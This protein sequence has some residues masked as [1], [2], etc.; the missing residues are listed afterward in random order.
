MQVQAAG[1][2]ERYSVST[3]LMFTTG[4][5][6][7]AQ[8]QKNNYHILELDE[9]YWFIG[10]KAKTETRE[11][12]YVM[13]MVSRLPRQIV[14][15]DV[16]FDK[17]SQRIQKIIDNGPKAEYYCTD[18]YCGYVDIVYPGKHIRNIHNKSDTFTVEGINADL[19]HYIPIL[20]RKSRCFSR[21]IETLRAVLDLFV[22]AYNAF[23]IAKMKFRKKRNPKSRELPFSVLDFL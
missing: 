16:A 20:R 22:Q 17:S 5:K 23:G 13:T 18:G 19:R 9:L 21:N 12:T 7:T 2:L 11:N 3:K 4:L 6:K 1:A 10:K 15:Y 14:G 8:I